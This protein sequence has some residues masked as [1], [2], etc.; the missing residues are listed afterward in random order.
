MMYRVAAMS[1]MVWVSMAV[2]GCSTACGARVTVDGQCED[3]G[4]GAGGTGSVGGTGG[5]GGGGDTGGTTT[6]KSTAEPCPDGCGD[7]NACTSDVCGA[8]GCEHLGAATPDACTTAKTNA[9]VCAW[10]ECILTD[11]TQAGDTDGEK[12]FREGGVGVCT[13]GFCAEACTTWADC[14]SPP[15]CQL[16]VCDAGICGVKPAEDGTLCT[17]SGPGG[18]SVCAGGVCL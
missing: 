12:C 3:S 6:T 5:A 8:N 18:M 15:E 11:C 1:A 13:D 16:P 7:G 14:P 4:A 2:I 10:T 9:G 17:G